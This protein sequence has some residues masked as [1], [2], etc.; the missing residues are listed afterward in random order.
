VDEPVRD[1]TQD[2]DILARVA[3]HHDRLE[4]II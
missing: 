3:E 4:L 1:H 2:P